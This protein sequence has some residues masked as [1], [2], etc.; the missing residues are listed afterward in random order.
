[1]SSTHPRQYRVEYVVGNAS[2]SEIELRT[3][4]AAKLAQ[5]PGSGTIAI[6]ADGTLIKVHVVTTRPEL[7]LAIGRAAGTLLEVIVEPR[8]ISTH[9]A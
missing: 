1:M 2:C 6:G 9:A 7:A 5:E 4:L 8:C 3:T